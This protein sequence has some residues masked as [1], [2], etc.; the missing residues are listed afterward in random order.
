[1]STPALPERIAAHVLAFN[2]AVVDGNWSAFAER[3]TGDATMRVLVVPPMEVAGRE[4]IRAAYQQQPPTD[5]LT[6]THADSLGDVDVVDFRWTSGG[7]GTMRLT[8]SGGLVASL[9]IRFDPPPSV[10]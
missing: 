3:F 2:Q 4:A 9:E 7:T 6:V 10:E 8:W 1:M 5:T